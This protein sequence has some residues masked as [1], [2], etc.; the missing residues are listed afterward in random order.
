[1]FYLTCTSKKN[2]QNWFCNGF[3]KKQNNHPNKFVI[4][5]WWWTILY[6]LI[7]SSLWCVWKRQGFWHI[8]VG[9]RKIL[10]DE[11]LQNYIPTISS[12]K[13]PPCPWPPRLFLPPS[14]N[15]WKEESKKERQ[16]HTQFRLLVS[17]QFQSSCP[18]KGFSKLTQKRKETKKFFWCN[19]LAKFKEATSLTVSGEKCSYK[20]ANFVIKMIINYGALK[21]HNIFLILVMI[22]LLMFHLSI[23][24]MALILKNL[25][26][27][28]SESPYI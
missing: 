21:Y 16:S 28:L 4:F 6:Y 15:N 8:K 1:M 25:Y 18:L 20:M 19:C 2:L 10:P 3:F 9:N 17:N 23:I 27:H 12:W 13:Q 14:K 11:N 24:S 26:L 7:S 22:P 5:L